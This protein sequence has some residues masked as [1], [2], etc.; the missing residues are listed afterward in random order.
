MLVY[1]CS[2]HRALEPPEA[3]LL[4]AL[5]VTRLLFQLVGELKY[6]TLGFLVGH[7]TCQGPVL[8]NLIPQ[9]SDV[10]SPIVHSLRS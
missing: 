5:N 3:D 1:I 8:G 6:L 7:R 4:P 2:V 10:G 9:F